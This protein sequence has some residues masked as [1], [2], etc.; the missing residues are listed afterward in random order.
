MKLT[1]FTPQE[2]EGL[3]DGFIQ[4]LEK[5]R[6]IADIPF[7]ITSGFRTPEKNQSVIGAVPDSAH[8]KGLA[9]D[10]KVDSSRQAA[11]IVDACKAAGIDRRGIYVNSDWNPIHIHVDVDPDKISNVLFIKKEQN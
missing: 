8:C 6:E 11:L 10:L 2:V 1:Y 9:V 4:K 3:Q 7:V 5:A